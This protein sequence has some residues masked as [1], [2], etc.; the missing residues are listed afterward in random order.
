MKFELQKGS[1]SRVLAALLLVVAAIFVL[2]LFYL[3]VIKHE[4]YSTLAD[5]EQVTRLKI[6][7][8]RGTIYALN[9]DE[10]VKLVMNETVYTMFADPAIID[11]EKKVIDVI[12]RVAGGNTRSGWEELLKKTD[13][14]YQIIATKVTRLQADKIKEESLRGI[15]FQAVSQRVYPEGSL[16]G[17]VL[18]FVNAEGVGNYGIEQAL[19]KE[20][21]GVDGRLEAVTD[22][23]DV[24][25]TIGN[26]NINI[27]AQ[28]GKNV[29]LSIDRNVQ[30]YV[31][32]AL[33]Q[34]V[35]R[36]GAKEASAIVIDPD[37]GQVMAMANL[38]SYSPEKYYEVN[39]IALFNNRSISVPYE[40]GSV[41]KVLTMATAVDKGVAKATDTYYNTDAITVDG[42]RI[43]NVVKGHT[44]DITFQTA[45]QWS[46]NTGFVTIAQRLGDGTT[47]TRS[48]RDTMYDYFYNRYHLGQLTGIQ[49]SGEAAGRIVAPAEIEGNAV[50]YSNM[51]FGQGMDSTMLQIATAFSSIINGGK[52]YKPTIV[53]GEIVSGSFQKS[54]EPTVVNQPV[55]A[56]T[57]AHI[58]DMLE[59]ARRES[60]G[61]L[62]RAGG[63]SIGGKTGTSETIKNGAYSDRQTI[64]SYVGY[65]G[66]NQPE[67]V[68][69]VQV[70]GDD[71]TLQGSRDAMPIFTDISN[72]LL[73]YKGIQPKG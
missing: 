62:D 11:D 2:R 43:T 20:L 26:R 33:R 21:Q 67:Y 41:V 68:I 55:S 4:Y 31:E 6:P 9:G 48:A 14:R 17:Q 70:A 69:M 22:V 5:S 25:L 16:A 29:V 13:S 24:P 73:G 19:D 15:G 63:Y 46:L 64:G 53:A 44:G 50:R 3:Q 71:Q 56:A 30:A 12:R 45:M 39:D 47:I 49:L 72:W 8:M 37:N 34:G 18:G 35:E 28:D 61:Y 51:S 1:R 60:H 38:P 42:R 32:Q 59:L 66:G 65:G 7:A 52:Y 27:P 36:T 58:R 40:P 10:P 23:A 57:S 54:P